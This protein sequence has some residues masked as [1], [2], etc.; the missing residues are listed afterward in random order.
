M[1]QQIVVPV[2]SSAE[3]SEFVTGAPHGI[4]TDAKTQ[5]YSSTSSWL[6]LAYG[7]SVMAALL[8]PAVLFSILL[9]PWR[10]LRVRIGNI[11]AKIVLAVAVPVLGTRVIVHNRERLT[12]QR[13][14]F[15]GNH[16][17]TIDMFVGSGVCPMGGCGTAKKEIVRVPVFGWI[18][19]LTGHLR[20]DRGNSE[21][22]KAALQ[23]LAEVVH[24]NKLSVYMWP[25]GTR[26]K[27]GRL[28]PL[29]KG[30]VHM[31]CATGLPIVPIVYHGAHHRWPSRTFR[32][33]PGEVHAYVLE[34]IDTSHWKPEEAQQRAQELWEMFRAHLPADQK[35]L[36]G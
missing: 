27:D 1:E 2:S 22:A 7:M 11:Y 23:S 21:K 10:G 12:L 30:F 28:Q 15:L 13:S 31:A 6:R 34:P 25:E 29:K 5:P 35:P 19:W 18:F 16:A 36:E 26:S 33:C 17:S 32:L 24:K 14:I 20:I 9:L 8:V 3:L 4:E